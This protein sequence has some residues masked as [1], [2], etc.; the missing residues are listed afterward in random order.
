MHKLL[1]VLLAAF[2]GS[3]FLLEPTHVEAKDEKKAEKDSYRLYRI[4]GRVW[5]LH[6]IPAPGQ[7]GGDTTPTYHKYEVKNVYEDRA[8]LAETTLDE[9]K[10]NS[11]DN[12]FVLKI[13]F[14]QDGP[15]FKDPPGY[16][17][18]KQEKVKTDA[19]TF[20]C[21]L[22]VSLGREDGDS[23]IWRSIDFPG[24]IV[25]QSDR[26]GTRTLTEFTWV[27]GDPGYK[28]PGKKKKKKDDDPEEIDPKRL[29][30]SKGATW[31]LRT[32][33]ERGER[34]TKSID[35]TQ[36][37]ITKVS[38][39]GCEIEVTKL[40]QL[41]ERMKGEDPQT[42]KIAFDDTYSAN[43]EP[44]ERSRV[45]RTELR[46]TDVGLFECTVYVY[47]D[48]EGREAR[49]WYAREWPGLVVRRVV[50]GENFK[51]LSKIIKFEE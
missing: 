50:E 14:K 22:W 29:Y 26:F 8:D 13:E 6:R 5:I 25:K 31:I 47:K 15:Q 24:L 3:L 27:E 28:A 41:L 32:D 51:Q 42:L 33:T 4:A 36:Y 21:I 7:E 18:S 20:D 23:R 11:S 10:K 30:S 35:V 39:E 45:E 37:E 34:G 38:E 44:K 1:L 2:C 16:T 46:I 17:K 43:L 48:E 9:A 12:E 19:G 49:A 40:T